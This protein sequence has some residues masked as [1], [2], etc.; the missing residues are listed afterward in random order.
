MRFKDFVKFGSQVFYLS[1]FVVRAFV[2]V[3]SAAENHNIRSCKNGQDHQAPISKVVSVQETLM[4]KAALR[5]QFWRNSLRNQS[6]LVIQDFDI[7]DLHAA[8]VSP[9]ASSVH[10]ARFR[11]RL[12]MSNGQERASHHPKPINE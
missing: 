8:I 10:T 6:S 4:Y 5:V 2:R 3:H 11:R 7:R 1:E 12:Q 9:S